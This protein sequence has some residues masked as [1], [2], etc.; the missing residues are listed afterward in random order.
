L[1]AGDRRLAE[2]QQQ[3]ERDKAEH[4][5]QMRQSAR[6]QNDAVSFKAQVD[7]L[8]KERGRLR[9]RTEQAAEHLASLDLELQELNTADDALQHRLAEERQTLSEIKQERD[10]IIKQRDEMTQQVFDLRAESSGVASRIEVLE[11]LERS[12]EGLGAGAREVLA[13]LVQE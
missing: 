9:M 8:N 7:N 6:L 2:L 4:L 11:G 12:H 5:D 13:V 3:V 10:R 1:T